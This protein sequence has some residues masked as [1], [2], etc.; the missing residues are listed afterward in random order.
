MRQMAPRVARRRPRTPKKRPRAAKKAPRARQKRVQERPG[1]VFGASVAANSLCE[2]PG[3]IFGRFVVA[4]L[5]GRATRATS[6]RRLCES[7]AQLFS[8]AVLQNSGTRE[9]RFPCA[10]CR[11]YEVLR[12]STFCLAIARMRRT[13]AKIKRGARK[14]RRKIDRR[15]DRTDD[16]KKARKTSKIE[17]FRPRKSSLGTSGRAKTGSDKARGTPWETVGTPWEAFLGGT[18]VAGTPGDPNKRVT[19]WASEAP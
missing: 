1:C 15:Y 3:L 17:V 2:A 7:A 16:R 4:L 13:H 14:I 10:L 12:G 11:F 8:H 9:P 6:V 19:T 18:S 5:D